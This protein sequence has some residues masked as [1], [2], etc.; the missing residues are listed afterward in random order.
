MSWYYYIMN[1][2]FNNEYELGQVLRAVRR[3][4]GVTQAELAQRAGVSRAFVI[5]LE[6][7]TNPRAETTRVMRV[8]RALGLRIRLEP[9]DAPSFAQALAQLTAGSAK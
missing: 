5:A 8:I 6:N 7:G 9:D 3:D 4:G 1:N 2:S